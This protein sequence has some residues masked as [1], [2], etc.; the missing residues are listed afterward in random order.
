MSSQMEEAIAYDDHHHAGYTDQNTPVR[1]KPT[2][3]GAGICITHM[4]ENNKREIHNCEL[5]GSFT[6]VA[7]QAFSG[8]H[9]HPFKLIVPPPLL[10][11]FPSYTHRETS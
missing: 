1:D 3:G 8:L 7:V 6:Y 2:G 10:P 4:A 5:S 11:F 9:R